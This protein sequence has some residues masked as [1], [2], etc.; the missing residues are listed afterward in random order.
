VEESL[1]K[2]MASTNVSILENIQKLYGGVASTNLAQTSKV[3]NLT[4]L[5]HLQ[6]VSHCFLNIED[7]I[8]TFKVEESIKEMAFDSFQEAALSSYR[9]TQKDDIL[10]TSS[11]LNKQGKSA[12]SKKSPSNII[13]SYQKFTTQKK[14]DKSL[15][16]SQN[17]N[18]PSM[19]KSVA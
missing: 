8:G 19:F 6:S 2:N 10:P 3:N 15:N 12:P 5:L 17:Q 18:N 14:R 11:S 4:G 9:S 16:C 13:Q 1:L 7:E